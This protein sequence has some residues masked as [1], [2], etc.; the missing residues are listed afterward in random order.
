MSSDAKD[1]KVDSPVLE[2]GRAV[3]AGLVN[4]RGG[5]MRCRWND[6]QRTKLLSAAMKQAGSR[7]KRAGRQATQDL[8][9]EV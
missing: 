9:K 1:D 7:R 4:Q 5:V 8:G 3:S 6:P 2:M